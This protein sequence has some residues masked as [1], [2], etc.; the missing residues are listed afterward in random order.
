MRQPL[1]AFCGCNRPQGPFSCCF[2]TVPGASSGG[3]ASAGFPLPGAPEVS[4]RGEAPAGVG[5]HG[6]AEGFIASLGQLPGL[7]AAGEDALLPVGALKLLL[8]GAAEKAGQQRPRREHR[9][10]RGGDFRPQ[11][12]LL[13]GFHALGC[14]GSPRPG[15]CA[16][17]AGGTGQCRR[18]SGGA[19]QN[20]RAGCRR[21]NPPGHSLA[22]PRGAKRRTPPGRPPAFPLGAAGGS[23]PRGRAP[24]WR[25]S[26]QNSSGQTGSPPPP[27]G[28][29]PRTAPP[30]GSAP[31][32]G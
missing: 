4:H 24:R 25:R 26:A 14:R 6:F 2:F 22:P 27:T 1:F 32:G 20:R 28:R 13:G 31:P 30:G 21:R 10:G 17:A 12:V 11:L 9:R 3:P 23:A 15:C 19:L 29:P 7:P 5:L 16:A 8:A 18:W